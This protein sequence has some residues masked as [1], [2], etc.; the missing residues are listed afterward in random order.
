MN[1]FIITGTEDRTFE[2]PGG[3]LLLDPSTG[4]DV[5]APDPADT[6]AVFTVTLP[7]N[8]ET[9]KVNG[10]ELVVG[11]VTEE[12]SRFSIQLQTPAANTFVYEYMSCPG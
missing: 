8:G 11:N 6:P 1:N 5:T 10:V 3:G 7:S 12:G 4:T 9:A 2:L